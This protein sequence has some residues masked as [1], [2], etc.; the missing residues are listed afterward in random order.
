MTKKAKSLPVGAILD[1]MGEDKIL[2]RCVL[3]LAKCS[4]NKPCPMHLKYKIIKEQLIDLFETETIG[5]LAY[6]AKSGGVFISNK[7][8]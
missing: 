5:K 7:K 1:A 2:D 8:K 3:G 4:E 6:D